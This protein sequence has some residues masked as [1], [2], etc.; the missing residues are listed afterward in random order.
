MRAFPAPL[1]LGSLLIGAAAHAAN[2]PALAGNLPSVTSTELVQTPRGF[3]TPQPTLPSHRGT[4]ASQKARIAISFSP[5]AN[6]TYQLDCV[7]GAAI[8]CSSDNFRALWT[9]EFLKNAS[10]SARLTEWRRVRDRYEREV[11]LPPEYGDSALLLPVGDNTLSL[12][13]KLRMAGFQASSI[14]N[15]ATSLDLVVTT[16]DRATLA[17]VVRHF[18]PRFDAWWQKEAMVR[19]A[20]FVQRVDALMHDPRVA[21]QLTAFAAFFES[22]LSASDTLQFTLLYRPTLGTRGPTRGEQAGRYALVEFVPDEQP[23]DRM[24]AVVHELCHYLMRRA[25]TPHALALYHAFVTSKDA[26]AI[27]AYNFLEETLA[28]AFGNGM[29][30]RALHSPPYFTAVLQ[31]PMTLYNNEAIDRGA[32]AVLPWL[33]QWL[34]SGRTLYDQSFA[35][36]YLARVDH[37]F[38]T[39][40]RA[41]RFMLNR[42]VLVADSGYMGIA[43]RLAR[44]AFMV[45]SSFDSNA[46]SEYRNRP[47]MTALVVV[48]PDHIDPLVANHILSKDDA[49]RLH[50]RTGVAGSALLTRERSKGVYTFTIVARDSAAIKSQLA[51]LAQQTLPELGL[52]RAQQQ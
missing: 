45:S 2:I 4:Y 26:N 12:S 10:D 36:E 32:K 37:E 23:E 38:G 15:Y 6:L 21:D 22:S 11:T 5:V 18:Q 39:S 47:H 3:V 50:A 46:L 16:D 27:P 19:G 41:P 42:M 35:R 52:A 25:P 24:D 28:T 13:H 14:D 8:S 30:A 40:L 48:H 31:K 29:I 20:P 7:S 9:R 49:L 17:A 33:D 44:G 43:S 51:L 34:A 1:L